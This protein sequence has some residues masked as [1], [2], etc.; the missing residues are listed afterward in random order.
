M[1]SILKGVKDNRH[2]SYIEYGSDI[3]LFSM[4]MKNIT[5]LESMNKMT[6]EFNR[7]EC[8]NNVAKALGYDKL[9][10]LPHHDTIYLKIL[11]CL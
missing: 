11:L 10:E 5:A 3:I 1:N 6:T 7:D 2:Q 4:L 8:I 9:E